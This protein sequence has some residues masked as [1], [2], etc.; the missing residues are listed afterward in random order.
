MRDRMPFIGPL[1][2]CHVIRDCLQVDHSP[3]GVTIGAPCFNTLRAWA[4]YIWRSQCKTQVRIRVPLLASLPSSN[5]EARPEISRGDEV[6]FVAPCAHTILDVPVTEMHI[7]I[8]DVL[9]CRSG[10]LREDVR[11][12]V[13]IDEQLSTFRIM[14]ARCETQ[15]MRYIVVSQEILT[16][17]RTRAGKLLTSIRMNPRT[18]ETPVSFGSPRASFYTS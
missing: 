3:A 1:H 2:A 11:V 7:E 9:I 17:V 15:R 8:H 5:N 16:P 6:A 13:G 14:R 12:R 10:V 18:P 4:L